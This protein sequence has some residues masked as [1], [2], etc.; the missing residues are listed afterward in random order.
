MKMNPTISVIVPVY[1]VAEYIEDAVLS[2]LNQ[3][4]SDLE[5]ILVNDGSTDDSSACCHR[6]AQRDSRVRMLDK[7]H[8]GVGASRNCGLTMACGDF[9]GFID[10]D[11]W[12]E[13]DFY[14]VLL[15]QLIQY[16]ADLSACGFV[17]INERESL[18]YTSVVQSSCCYSREEAM[19][20]L[21][22]FNHMR[23]SSC[24]KL[25]KA[26]L[27]E[28]IA[29]PVDC[30]IDD[31]MTIYKLIHKSERIAWC[32]SPKYHYYMRENSIMHES[33]EVI[34]R[35]I[36]FANTRLEL[37]ISQEYPKLL[38]LMQS[39]LEDEMNKIVEKK[40]IISGNEK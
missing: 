17:K 27:F 24:N 9:I 23:Y 36:Q 5:V 6:L 7:E 11:D 1:N 31:K 4:Y 29:Y 18:K 26:S 2:I 37:F 28:S 35:N 34:L 20:K 22:D 12:I 3:T 16:D 15:Q 39:C 38:P 32:S 13:P 30:T 25:F 10:G 33:T 19:E 14:E 40:N 21:F 8:E